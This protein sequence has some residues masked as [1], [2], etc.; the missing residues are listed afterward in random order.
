MT[1]TKIQGTIK[2]NL[3]DHGGN[4][5]Y[6]IGDIAFYGINGLCKIVDIRDEAFKGEK[7]PYYILQS[8]LYPSMTLYYPVN[9]ENSKLQKVISPA[10]ANEILD[11]FK[12]EASEWPERNAVRNQKYKAVIG[13]D[14]HLEIAQFLNTILRKQ[15]E[16]I[17]LGKKLSAQDAQMAQQISTNLYDEL[18]ISLKIPKDQISK[19]IASYI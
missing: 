13:S 19:K 5:M 3:V 17:A 14:N 9:V 11:V 18:S 12:N 15:K 6:A 8:T 10:L 4:K 16:L 2:V 1:K 7:Q